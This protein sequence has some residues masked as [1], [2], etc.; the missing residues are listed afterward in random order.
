M[1]AKNLL[2]SP[3]FFQEFW[4]RGRC[5]QCLFSSSLNILGFQNRHELLRWAC[6]VFRSSCY[7]FLK[8]SWPVNHWRYS[9]T[10]MLTHANIRSISIEFVQVYDREEI[11]DSN[12]LH[13]IDTYTIGFTLHCSKFR[14]KLW[15]YWMTQFNG[16]QK[17]APLVVLTNPS[18]QHMPRA[19]NSLLIRI[20]Q[21]VHWFGT[22]FTGKSPAQ[23]TQK[24]T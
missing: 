4:W 21:Y 3:L 15:K 9:S 20:Q 14:W 19:T 16:H 7:R 24:I 11:L 18:N 10:R 6:K 8:G 5:S 17:H 13:L 2:L 22:I 23:Q 1:I 12:F